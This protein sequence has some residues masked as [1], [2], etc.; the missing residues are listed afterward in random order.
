MP[1]GLYRASLEEKARENQIEAQKYQFL[2]NQAAQDYQFRLGQIEADTN[3]KLGKIQ[4]RYQLASTAL[5]SLTQLGTAAMN[6]YYQLKIA[7]NNFKLDTMK[8]QYSLGL[9]DMELQMKRTQWQNDLN[10]RNFNGALQREYMT[11]QSQL[12]QADSNNPDSMEN[13]YEKFSAKLVALNARHPNAVMDSVSSGMIAGLKDQRRALLLETPAGQMSLGQ[14]KSHVLA[15]ATTPPGETTRYV[16]E[17]ITGNT[18]NLFVKYAAAQGVL[19]LPGAN[20]NLLEAMENVKDQILN[21]DPNTIDNMSTLRGLIQSLETEKK[22]ASDSEQAGLNARL[23]Q[24]TVRLSALSLSALPGGA[25]EMYGKP[26]T[27]AMV[28]QI[29]NIEARYK[30]EEARK[31][32]GVGGKVS[33]RDLMKTYV[34]VG[35]LE[36]PDKLNPVFDPNLSGESNLKKLLNVGVEFRYNEL[37]RLGVITEGLRDYLADI[38]R[39]KPDFSDLS[40][41]QISR[42]KAAKSMLDAVPALE[43]RIKVKEQTSRI[44]GGEALAHEPS[45]FSVLLPGGSWNRLNDQL[46]ERLN[47]VTTKQPGKDWE[48]SEQKQ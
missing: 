5:N 43:N 14:A 7:E 19:N 12:A 44:L 17:T 13:L 40:A 23:R 25:A 39:T 1:F 45:L 42:V 29:S 31:Q 36:F 9:Q 6:N 27:E 20:A 38:L 35:T 37:G 48:A 11:F 26:L 3:L 10:D 32:L 2:S 41:D 33:A 30:I 8:L 47:M 18:P 24:A 16:P 28:G 15:G 46:T 4:G 34:E 21:L 22:L